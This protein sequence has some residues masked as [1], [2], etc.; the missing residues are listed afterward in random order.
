MLRAGRGAPHTSASVKISVVVPAFN[1]ERLLPPT[2]RSTRAAAGAFDARGW[3]WE[4]IVCD[5]NSTDRTG[6]IARAGGAEVVFEPVNQIAR[7]RNTGAASAGGD[8]LVFVDA[9]SRPDPR[10]APGSAASRLRRTPA[11]Q[12]RRRQRWWRL[13]GVRRCRLA[14]E[15]GALRGSG[16]RDRTRPLP[17]RREHGRARHRPLRRPV[18]RGALEHAQP[19]LALGLG[20]LRLL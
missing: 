18:F 1:E 20:L 7:A 16:R 19:H 14:A 9:D 8:W 5:N 6:E 12:H 13:A 10:R 2:L 17:R 3:R 15:P 11:S 4:L